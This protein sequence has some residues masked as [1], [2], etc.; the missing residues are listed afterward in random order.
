[1]KSIKR[2][3]ITVVVVFL[4][5]LVVDLVFIPMIGT[6][7]SSTFQTVS[8]PRPGASQSSP[9]LTWVVVPGLGLGGLGLIYWANAPKRSKDK[10]NDVV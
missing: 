3:V 7:A 1:M 9:W 5:L 2:I 4:L 10:P 6:N 8:G